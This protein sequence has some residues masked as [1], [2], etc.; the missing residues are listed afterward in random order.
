MGLNAFLT[1]T[2]GLTQLPRYLPTLL[3]AFA[4]FSLVHQVLAPWGS[5]RWFPAAYGSKGR[6]A[7]NS[8]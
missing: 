3:A 1:D 8:W 6:R 4:G 5:A 7:R 2:L